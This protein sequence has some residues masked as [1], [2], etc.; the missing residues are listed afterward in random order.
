MDSVKRVEE[1]NKV[2]STSAGVRGQRGVIE[3]VGMTLR[4]GASGARIGKSV[5]R[6]CRDTM[7]YNHCLRDKIHEPR[8]FV[9][10]RSWGASTKPTILW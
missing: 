3:D 6:I 10:T 5:M 4:G 1:K 9:R 8:R 7:S 2:H